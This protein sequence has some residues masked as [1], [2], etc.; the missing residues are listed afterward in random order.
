LAGDLGGTA[1]LPTVPGLAL[2]SPLAGS[3]SITTLGTIATGTWNGTTVAVANGGTGVT[4][5]TGSGSVVLST[6]P[7]LVSPALGTP[8]SAT[9][10][11]ATGLPI[12]SG[13]SG[14]GTGVATFLATPSSANLISIVTDGTGS[15]SLVFASSPALTTPN[16]GVA[17]GTSLSTT[18][19][20]TSSGT[21]GIG[22]STGAGGSVTQGSNKTTG[23]TLNK[24]T[25]AITTA[26]GSITSARAIKFTVSNTLVAATDIPFVAIKSGAASSNSYTVSVGAVA[27]GSFDIVI[28]N[29]TGA[30]LNETL[31]INFTILKGVI[32]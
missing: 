30:N 9:L 21:A 14:L 1:A 28:Y 22:Y 17:T 25:G 31:V 24:M 32:N 10:T 27:A 18:G 4:T 5:S 26:A 2:K 15:G 8:T 29:A 20:I 16:I 11:N 7:T 3:T 23:V 12:S 19:S 6:S 13:V